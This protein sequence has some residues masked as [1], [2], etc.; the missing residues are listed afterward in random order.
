VTDT[1]TRGLK[2]RLLTYY[3]LTKPGIIYGNGLSA[4][5]GFFLATGHTD[6]FDVG[7]FLAAM[8]GTALVIAA[9]CVFNNY[10][11]VDIDKKMQR[12]RERALVSGSVSKRAAVVYATVLAAAGFASLIFFT[13]PLTVLLGVIGLFSYVVLYSAAKRRGPYG[14]LVGSISG[15]TPIT[16]GYT[17]VTGH[18]DAGAI[19]LFGIMALWQMP[20]FYAIALYRR[21]EYKRAGVPVLAVVHGA[22]LTKIYSVCFIS[23]FILAT[24]MLS[25][26]GVTG[27]AYLVGIVPLG[28][29]WL[30][31]AMRGFTAAD[32]TK[33]ARGLFGVSLWVLLGFC[34]L[35]SLEVVLP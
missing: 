2:E 27:I 24:I 14:T 9:G 35:I 34:A 30:W 22:R 23:L 20:H 1:P 21:E 26:Y 10:L 13:N 17:A 7:L 8:L 15:A 6:T 18:L 19:I 28:L 12:T 32:D 5:A 31:L 4:A 3:R 25:V 29:W 16:A 33:W 11:D